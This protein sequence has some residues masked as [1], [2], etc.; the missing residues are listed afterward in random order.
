MEIRNFVTTLV[1][2]VSGSS[3]SGFNSYQDAVKNYYEAKSRG[4]VRVEREPGDE[5]MF[6]P[7]SQAIM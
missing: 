7:L 2:G 4:C 6:S 1:S 5:A 3:F